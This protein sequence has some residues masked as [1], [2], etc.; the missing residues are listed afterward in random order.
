MAKQRVVRVIVVTMLKRVK[1][2]LLQQPG[3]LEPNQLPRKVRRAWPGVWRVSA[4]GA[5]A[6]GESMLCGIRRIVT[7][8]LGS[9]VADRAEASSRI[10]MDRSKGA[11]GSIHCL[12][13][14]PWQTIASIPRGFAGLHLVDAREA[15]EICGAEAIASGKELGTQYHGESMWMFED[16]RKAVLNELG[17]T[18][19]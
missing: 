12:V 2:V 5:L 7:Q 18:E 14:V 8:Q 19:D 1:H 16:E 11:A 9:A 13:Y 17:V 4:Y 15:K 3:I 10:G 6:S